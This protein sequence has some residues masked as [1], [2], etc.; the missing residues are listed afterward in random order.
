MPHPKRIISQVM[1]KPMNYYLRGV[2]NDRLQYK[3]KPVYIVR[4]SYA[5]INVQTER[6]WV[7]GKGV[8][9]EFLEIFGQLCNPCDCK[10]VQI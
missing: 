3:L 4:S 8:A 9:F 10:I 1:R 5:G 2:Y 6:G 7:A